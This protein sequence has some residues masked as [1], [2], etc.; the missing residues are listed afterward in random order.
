MTE[1]AERETRNE[2]IRAVKQK[3]MAI[4]LMSPQTEAELF[5]ERH[6]A[7]FFTGHRDIIAP[8]GIS[9]EQFQQQM[10]LWL[11]EQV[12]SMIYR[13]FSTFLCGGARGFDLLAAA[14]VLHA[15]PHHDALRLIML[16]PCREQTRGWSTR[17]LALHLAVL[18][19]AEAFYLQESYDRSCMQRRNRMLVDNAIA[20]IAYYDPE[21]ARS[22]TGMTVRYADVR[23]L[24]MVFMPTAIGDRS[25][26]FC[27]EDDGI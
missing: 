24:P 18:E 17:D 13:G 25:E 8:G 9:S 7:C 22:G 26:R 14:A 23:G 6:Q 16:L 3:T 1:T 15:K 12:E 10:R 4:P 11:E 19:R 2:L 5:S 27:G 21:K 20:G